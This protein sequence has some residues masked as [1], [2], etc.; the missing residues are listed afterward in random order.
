MLS[1]TNLQPTLIFQEK[2]HLLVVSFLMQN[3][4][5]SVYGSLL[6]ADGGKRSVLCSFRM[7]LVHKEL[8]FLR[9]P[10]IIEL[11]GNFKS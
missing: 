11:R 9:F 2:E 5:F 10:Q 6:L 3:C 7:Q 4:S 8:C 1:L